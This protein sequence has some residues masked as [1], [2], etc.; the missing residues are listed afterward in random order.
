M[1]ENGGFATYRCEGM[2][3]FK[4]GSVHLP[5]SGLLELYNIPESTIRTI[6][7]G[8]DLGVGTMS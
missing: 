3:E 1:I 4:A 8:S 2:I 5:R 7:A 6:L